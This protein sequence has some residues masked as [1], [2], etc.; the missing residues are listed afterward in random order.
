MPLSCSYSPSYFSFI[1][2]FL[3]SWLF[4]PCFPFP[5]SPS[6]NRC[7]RGNHSS[8]LI[9]CGENCIKHTHCDGFLFTA[10]IEALNPSVSFLFVKTKAGIAGW[11]L[12]APPLNGIQNEQILLLYWDKIKGLEFTAAIHIQKHTQTLANTTKAQHTITMNSN[13]INIFQ[14]DLCLW[15]QL[16]C[17][18]CAA[19]V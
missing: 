8:A 9:Q 16:L 18:G 12:N 2:S 4:A 6:P 19:V 1:L 10:V 13:Y 7:Y 17:F 14:W 11:K 3:L 5:F 15:E